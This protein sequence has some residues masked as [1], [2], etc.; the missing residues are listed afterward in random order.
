MELRGRLP[1]NDEAEE[2]WSRIELGGTETIF[3]TIELF[4][5]PEQLPGTPHTNSLETVVNTLYFH[6][7]NIL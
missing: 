5:L 7:Q 6:S 1:V 2:A 4:I 3:Y